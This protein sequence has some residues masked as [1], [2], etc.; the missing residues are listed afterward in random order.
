MVNKK[1]IV[2][3]N[4]KVVDKSTANIMFDTHNRR[5][6]R[7]DN[8]LLTGASGTVYTSVLVFTPATFLKMW[9]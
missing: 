7:C 3:S 2:Y 5:N 6:Y 9:V 4:N 8:P 1:K